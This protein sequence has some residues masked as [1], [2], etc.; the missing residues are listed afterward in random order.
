MNEI[1]YSILR[2]CLAMSAVSLFPTALLAVSLML[3]ALVS[4]YAFQYAG[5][6]RKQ[7]LR[8]KGNSGLYYDEDGSATHET[9]AVFAKLTHSNNSAILTATLAGFA[10]AMMRAI[11]AVTLEFQA[12]LLLDRFEMI[13]IGLN[14]C[15][16]V[17]GHAH[18][19]HHSL[20]Y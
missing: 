9:Q 3:S 15:A 12:P 17:S 2:D 11:V 16:I 5:G 19:D 4:L 6:S 13:H 8:G 14:L 1:P 7:I 20:Q 18:Y 10:V